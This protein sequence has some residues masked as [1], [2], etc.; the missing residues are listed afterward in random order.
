MA[1][2]PQKYL[3]TKDGA[4][5]DQDSYFV[6]RRGDILGVSMLRSYQQN[7][8]TLLDLDSLNPAMTE[9]QREYLDDLA[10]DVDDLARKWQ[11]DESRKI[12]D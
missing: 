4:R 2:D 5:L 1:L 12:P 11:A 6:I 3:V 9:E 10:D 7:V 8:I